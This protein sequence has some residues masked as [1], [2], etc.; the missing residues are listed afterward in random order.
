MLILFLMLI[1]FV[2]A[3]TFA[4]ESGAP[5]VAPLTMQKDTARIAVAQIMFD[6]EWLKENQL[7]TA[8]RPHVERAAAEGADLIVFPEYLLGN[9]KIP[10]AKTDAVCALARDNNIN[11]IAGGWEFLEDHPIT[12]PPVENTFA[13]ST[14]I[15]NRHGEIVGKHHKMH[16][17]L[18]AESPY[19]WPPKPGEIS[20]VLMRPGDTFPVVALDFGRISVLTCYDGYFFSSFEMPSL[21]GAEVLVWVNG[22][23]GAVEEH[24]VRTASFMT[25]T[26]VV[27]SNMA[28]G[29]GSMIC[30][31]PGTVQ[32]IANAPEPTFIIADLSLADLRVQRKNNRMFHQRRPEMYGDIARAWEPWNAYP[33]ISFFTYDQKE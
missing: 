17:A 23:A 19:F 25:C 8:Y 30:A 11:L 27:A 9:F 6:E 32:A 12:A 1:V 3:A 5:P 15:I 22:R 16:A 26:H 24:L 33:G 21:K 29:Q 14:L 4:V 2:C 10:D 20:E 18:G 31:Y 13:N 28:V 7:L